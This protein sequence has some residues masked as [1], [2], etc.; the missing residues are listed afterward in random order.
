MITLQPVSMIRPNSEGIYAPDGGRIEMDEG[1]F[2]RYQPLDI[3]VSFAPDGYENPQQV[4]AYSY[5]LD[6]WYIIPG[7][8]L[9]WLTDADAAELAAI[10]GGGDTGQQPG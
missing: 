8:R 6:C 2:E 5:G 4:T 7:Q 1:Q 3:M 10:L 9:E